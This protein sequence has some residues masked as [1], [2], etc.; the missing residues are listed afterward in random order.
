MGDLRKKVLHTDFEGKDSCTEIP[1][2]K[3]YLSCR[4]LEKKCLHRC[5]SRKKIISPGV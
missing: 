1:G 4:M 2:K 5:M 3:K